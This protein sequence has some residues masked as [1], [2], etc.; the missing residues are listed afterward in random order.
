MTTQMN[1]IR[2]ISTRL[3]GFMQESCGAVTIDWVVIT[4]AVAGLGMAVTMMLSNTMATPSNHLVQ[5]L[6]NKEISTT[7]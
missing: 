1:Q 3:R 7:F 2:R 4:A 5:Y 6:S